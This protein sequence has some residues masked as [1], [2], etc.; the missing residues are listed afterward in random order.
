MSQ[1]KK[2]RHLL[3]TFVKSKALFA[4]F[5]LF[6]SLLLIVGSTYA[7]ITSSDER[8]NQAERNSRKLSAVIEE[9]FTQVFHWAPGTKNEKKIRVK[10]DGETPAIVRVSLKEFFIA[11]ETDKTDNHGAGDGNG[12]LKVYA[13]PSTTSVDVKKTDTWVA[14]NTYEVN[15]NTYYKANHALLD[16]TYQYKGTRDA[17]LPAFELAFQT[18]KVFDQSNPP[19]AGTSEYWY[20]EGGYFYYSEV[21]TPSQVTPN[22]LESVSLDPAYAN[23]YKGAL[24]KLVPEMDA[25]DVTR[26]LISDWGISTTGYV[27]Q[28][29]DNKLY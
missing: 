29:Y 11:F 20:Y 2:L 6:L 12:N 24:Y 5:S 15:A 10:N 25:H 26:S 21:M 8:I 13:A 3:Q 4:C 7:W 19:P 28:M 17:P 27:Y 16:K 23:Q 1:N 18:S 9:D 22:L 14:G